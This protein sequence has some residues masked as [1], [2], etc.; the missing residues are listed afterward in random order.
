[1]PALL[2]TLERTAVETGAADAMHLE[3]GGDDA[4]LERRGRDRHLERGSRRIAA[5]DRAIVERT[6]LVGRQRR[7]G[8]A[9]DAGGERVRIVGRT[10]REPEHVAVG[11]VDDDGGA[12]E[13]ELIEPVL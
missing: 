3:V 4:F 8:G 13:S 2:P 5:L 11:R 9:V 7:P 12:V 10:A 6:L 1:V